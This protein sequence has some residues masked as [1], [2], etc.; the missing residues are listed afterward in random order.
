LKFLVLLCFE[1]PLPVVINI[2]INNKIKSFSFDCTAVLVN[3][4]AKCKT[5]KTI[6]KIT[7]M[8]IFSTITVPGAFWAV[9]DVTTLQMT[10]LWHNWHNL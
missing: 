3:M 2:I 1:I 6:N 7:Y 4:P 9:H 8:L 5:W 10:K